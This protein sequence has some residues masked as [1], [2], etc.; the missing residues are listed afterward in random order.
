M[1]EKW[2]HSCCAIYRFMPGEDHCTMAEIRAMLPQ[3]A[4]AGYGA[5]QITAPYASA[6][7]TP[8][9]GLRPADCFAPNE[10]LKCE[11]QD[12]AELARDCHRH[13]LRLMYFINLGYADV[14][15]ELWR[16]ACRERRAGTKG[17]AS[18]LFCWEGDPVYPGNGHF[19][20]GGYMH[21][22][23]EAGS[24]YWSKWA[25]GD[26]AEPQYDWNKPQTRTFVQMVLGH[27][28]STGADGII[29]D[30]VNWYLNCDMTVIRRYVTDVAHRFPGRMCIAEGSTG[31]GDSFEPWLIHGGF[32]GIDGQSLHS[33][34]HWNG[35]A[36]YDALTSGDGAVLERA[37]TVTRKARE[38][39]AVCWN[40]LSWGEGWTLEKRLMEIA[41][42]IAVGHMTEILPAYLTEMSP[43]QRDALS[44]LL[45]MTRHSALA[46]IARRESVPIPEKGG[47]ACLCPEG[48]VPV[49]CV[50]NLSDRWRMFTLP[51]MEHA[52]WRDGI[53]G[54][55]FFSE[56]D[57]ISVPLEAHS[58]AFLTPA[59][60]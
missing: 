17:E 35:S 47:W 9:W 29:V 2:W 30:A 40:Y 54:A 27:W 60:L 48:A 38:M 21:R 33:D 59:A 52:A 53:S 10:H 7:F 12:F 4:E 18:G 36:I 34:L 41:L 45:K 23:E 28:L 20:Q 3:L 50:F 51:A 46:P 32:D 13:G 5:I 26:L 25:E 56:W 31:F 58:F 24:H 43:Q 16:R 19:L 11:M 37:L 15:S 49:L 6:G 57:G 39:G 55:E 44:A 22:S 1:S 42:L 14:H 8:W